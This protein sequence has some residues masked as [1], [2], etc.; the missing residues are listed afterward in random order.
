L[1][2]KE[3]L[4]TLRTLDK[5]EDCPDELIKLAKTPFE[6]TVCVEFFKLYKEFVTH[7]AE[8]KSDMR[9]LKWLVTS[10]FSV[11]VITLLFQLIKGLI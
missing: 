4:E 3:F 10:V 9:W 11:S 7:K 8:Q 6:K 2:D 5:A 1:D